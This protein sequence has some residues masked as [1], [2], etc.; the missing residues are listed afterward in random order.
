MAEVK[1]PI[2]E[3]EDHS[4]TITE[5]HTISDIARWL[6]ETDMADEVQYFLTHP[7]E[8]K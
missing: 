1:T 3:E 2:V 6:I 4:V 7:D 5:D 8:L